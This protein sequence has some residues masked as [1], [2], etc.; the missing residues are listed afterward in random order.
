MTCINDCVRSVGEVEIRL[1]HR[2]G[3]ED[4][5]LVKNAVVNAARNAQANA[6]CNQIGSSFQFYVDRMIFGT[7]GTLGGAPKVVEASRNGLFGPTLV[8]K[9]VLSAVNPNALNQA[10][11]TAVMGFDEGNGSIINEMGLLMKS[12]DLYSMATLGGIS[13]DS[14]VQVIFNWKISML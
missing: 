5:V 2:G 7:N 11:F 10:M 9:Q 1:R 3:R 14:T 12:G 4:V 13:K 8:S 6:L